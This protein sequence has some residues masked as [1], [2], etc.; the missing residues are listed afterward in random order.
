MHIS[1]ISNI[2]SV[3]ANKLREI[4]SILGGLHMLYTYAFVFY[5]KFCI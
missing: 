2:I 3:A 4:K 1:S 5:K